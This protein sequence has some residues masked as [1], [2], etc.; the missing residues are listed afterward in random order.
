MK[1]QCNH[2]DWMKQFQISYVYLFMQYEKKIRKLVG[3]LLLGVFAI[4]LIHDLQPPILGS[5]VNETPVPVSSEVPDTDHSDECDDSCPCIIHVLERTVSFS[6]YRT[7][8]DLSSSSHWT[9]T[10][11]K[12]ENAY[13][14][15]ID[16]PP[17]A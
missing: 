15:G 11:L 8:H 13:P 7:E 9:A 2:P 12:P 14:K 10:H 17:E 5:Q 16:R 4:I 6:Q 1:D 3:I